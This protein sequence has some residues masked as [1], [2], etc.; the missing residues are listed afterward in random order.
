MNGDVIHYFKA[1][2][3]SY[4]TIAIKFCFKL[5]FHVREMHKAVCAIGDCK[6]KT[7]N[8]TGEKK[9]TK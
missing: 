4:I 9:M 2:D 7:L 6:K 3:L 1:T 5:L 8:S